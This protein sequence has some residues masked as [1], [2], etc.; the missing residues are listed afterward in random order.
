[1]LVTGVAR[2]WGA[3]LVQRLVD[4]R[5]VEEV[6]GIDT[7]EPHHDLG[8]ADFLKLDI[9]HSLVGKLVRA[10]GIDTVVHTQTTID[11]F[12]QDPRGAHETNVIGTINLLG[13]LA[14]GDTPVKRLVLKSSSHV[15]GSHHAL[16]GHLKEDQ[17]LDATSP[18][19]FVRDI[20]E[21]ETNLF[22]FAVRNPEVEAVSL[23]FANALNPEEPAPLA[24]YFDLPVVPTVIGYD[25]VL[26]LVHR[27]D[28]IEALVRACVGSTRGAYNIAGENA[29]PLSALLD[30]TGK[31]HAPLLP[32][33]GAM[34]L[35]P[36]LSRLGIASLT[37]QLVDLLR[38][39]RTLDLRRAKLDLGFS[40]GYDTLAALD[41]YV[42]QRRVL[43]FLPGGP[44]YLYERELEEY[45]HNRRVRRRADNGAKLKLAPQPGAEP[46][47]PPRRP[48]R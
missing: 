33:A 31:V 46:S 18:H 39:G 1:M 19:A 42:Q 27:D 35:S 48:H 11:S 30:G 4:E 2:W 47:V 45:I 44:G 32:P 40:A 22:D 24:R 8:D 3:L 34:V 36:L 13:G 28:C 26:Q 25:P 14:G 6:I 16:P 15:Y 20:V 41:D 23:R 43:Q 21:S 10:V 5:D 12:D 38:W 17:R 29:L 7:E 37:P 9:R